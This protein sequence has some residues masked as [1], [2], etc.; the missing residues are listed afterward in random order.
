MRPSL[1]VCE[2]PERHLNFPL[3]RTNR[4]KLSDVGVSKTSPPF[5][6]NASAGYGAVITNRPGSEWPAAGRN[7]KA[8]HGPFFFVR[9]SR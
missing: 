7:A 1:Q 2:N 8:Q 3:P 4:N 5:R 6:G 9:D